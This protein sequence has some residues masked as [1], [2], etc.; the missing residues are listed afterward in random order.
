MVPFVDGLVKV[1]GSN[2]VIEFL[3]FGIALFLILLVGM[4]LWVR[5]DPQRLSPADFQEMQETFLDTEKCIRGVEA[6]E[7]S[8]SWK[9]LRVGK[10]QFEKA[11]RE[12]NR[13][14]FSYAFSLI[15]E[16]HNRAFH[17]YYGGV[18]G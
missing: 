7:D 15:R 6:R 4:N 10:G 2:P 18:V 14:N 3:V 8:N 11:K 12:R 5:F 13:G 9:V 16:A 17:E 1:V